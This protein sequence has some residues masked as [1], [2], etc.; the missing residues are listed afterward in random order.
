MTTSNSFLKD[1]KRFS[2]IPIENINVKRVKFAKTTDQEKI[3][4]KQNIFFSCEKENLE[5]FLGENVN[6]LIGLPGFEHKG[7][8]ILLIIDL[9]TLVFYTSI[10]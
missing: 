4:G 10:N 6:M 8:L 1:P 3:E 9:L 2:A 5:N 7:Y